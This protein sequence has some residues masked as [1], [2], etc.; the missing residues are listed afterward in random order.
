MKKNKLLT[1]LLTSIISLS[2]TACSA[3]NSTTATSPNEVTQLETK[4]SKKILVISK[5][6]E[7]ME[8]GLCL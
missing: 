6:W 1:I 4:E 8:Y 3:T 7:S 2:V 5:I